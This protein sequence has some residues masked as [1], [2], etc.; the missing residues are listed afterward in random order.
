MLPPGLS[1]LGLP[2]GISSEGD[3]YID[4]VLSPAVNNLV[5]H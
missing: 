1:G 2:G 5:A 4:G 3:E